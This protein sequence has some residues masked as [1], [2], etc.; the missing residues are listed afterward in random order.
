MIILNIINIFKVH[1]N[2]A[3]LKYAFYIFFSL[4]PLVVLDC[5]SLNP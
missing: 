4:K 2:F 5:K 1:L 3:T